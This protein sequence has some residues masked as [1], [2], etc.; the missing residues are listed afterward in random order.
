MILRQFT[1]RNQKCVENN[2]KLMNTYEYATDKGKINEIFNFNVDLN[3]V[4]QEKNKE[5]NNKQEYPC[6]E[7][8]E[9]FSSQIA[10]SI[11]RQTKHP[12]Q[13]MMYKRSEIENKNLRIP[14]GMMEIKLYSCNRCDYQSRT[15]RLLKKHIKSIH[16]GIR[17]PCDQCEYKA[18]LPGHLK[19]H[20]QVQHDEIRYYCDQCKFQAVDKSYLKAHMKSEH[21]GVRHS[22]NECDYQAMTKG[23]L[24]K[25]QQRKHEGLSFL[26]MEC[27]K[28]L[29]SAFTLK[30]HQEIRHS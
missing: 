13:G 14:E 3:Q 15:T 18:K 9:D 27:D 24:N 26:C 28:Q 29:Y 5:E 22:C 16:L 11:H 7:C 23:V 17:Y 21:E 1:E 12:V 4:D 25:H 10:L 6:V 30:K 19:T 8:F 20:K 2:D